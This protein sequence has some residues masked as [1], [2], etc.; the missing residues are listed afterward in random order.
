MSKVAKRNKTLK[1][2]LGVFILLSFVALGGGWFY[3]N[4]VNKEVSVIS[5]EV[6]YLNK[7]SAD[8]SEAVQR[9]KRVAGYESLVFDSL[10]NTK[11]ISSFLADFEEV[12]SRNNIK[13][14]S[15]TIGA[16]S[17]K[18]TKNLEL[19]QTVN[20]KDYYELPIKYNVEGSYQ[21]FMQMLTDL[22][23]L[24]RLNIVSDVSIVKNATDTT[25]FVQ[26]N[27]VDSIY[28]KK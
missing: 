21:S 7:E 3:A 1:I 9:Y 10:P 20:Q 26:V 13:V 27:F 4:K 17:T 22:S 15:S 11:E 25:D 16:A 12:A 19:S 6:K 28:I 8:K 24:R 23:S 18:G 14:N 2:M 5:T